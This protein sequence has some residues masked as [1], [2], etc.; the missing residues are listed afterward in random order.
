[1]IPFSPENSKKTLLWTTIL[2]ALGLGILT[3]VCY[4]FD[5]QALRSQEN[6]FNNQQALQT[7][8]A[9]ESLKSELAT[10]TRNFPFLVREP[11]RRLAHNELTI[12][13]FR[14]KFKELGRAFP[15]IIFGAMYLAP[16]NGNILFSQKRAQT[17]SL[18]QT[19]SQQ[20]QKIWPKFQASPSLAHEISFFIAQHKQFVRIFLPFRAKNVLQGIMV[21]YVD[22]QPFVD[23]Y[24][25][26]MHSGKFGA[27]Y[28]LSE[29][30]TIIFDHEHNIIGRNV[31][32]SLH[33]GYPEL[34][35]IDR[36][37]LTKHEGTGSYSFT[38]KR[39]GTTQRKLVAWDT[40]PLD[41]SGHKIIVAMSAPDQG[42]HQYIRTLWP[43]RYIIVIVMVLLALAGIIIFINALTT[44]RLILSKEQSF[45]VIDLLPDATFVIDTQNRIMAWNKAIE[46]M[47]GIP[48]ERVLG[49]NNFTEIIFGHP[50]PLLANYLDRDDLEIALAYPSFQKENGCLSAEKFIPELYDGKGAHLWFTASR[51]YDTRDN[52]I[53]AIESIRDISQFKKTEKALQDSR[54]RFTL[55]VEGNYT[56]IWDWDKL[57]DTVY[58]APRWKK[59]IGFDDDEFPNDIEAWKERIHPEDYE[60]VVETN[61]NLSPT[62]PC[63]EIEYRIRSKNGEY[64]WIAGHG[65]GI[66]DDQGVLYRMAGSH[67]D[68]TERKQNELILEALLRISTTSNRVRKTEYLFKEIHVILKELIGAENFFIAMWNKDRSTITFPYFVDEFDD[69]RCYDNI[70]IDSTLEQPGLISWVLRNEKPLF[71]THDHP[72][73]HECRGSKPA[74]W[75]GVPIIIGSSTRGVLCVQDYHDANRFTEK[76]LDFLFAVAEQTALALDR[77]QN[78]QKMA[79]YAMHDPLTNLPN[80]ALFIDRLELSI[81]RSQR[82]TMYNF[83]VMM[84]DLDRFKKINDSMG[85]ATGDKLL[86]QLSSRILP[87]LR[88]VDTIARIGG[89]EFAVLAEDFHTPREIIVIAKRI[90]AAIQQPFTIGGK[91]IHTN[92]S[93]GIVINTLH[94]IQPDTILRDA[95]I[96]MYEAKNLGPGRVRVF[97]K[98]MHRQAVEVVKLENDLRQALKEEQINV[99][100][101]PVFS[102]DPLHIS[103]VEALARWRHPEKGII[104]PDVFIPLAEET[105]LI[106]SLGHYI[107]NTACSTLAQWNQTYAGELPLIMAV[108]LSA[109]QL[110]HP[111]IVDQVDQAMKNYG[112]SGHMLKLEIT[113][114]TFM[115][116]P[117]TSQMVL[118]MLKKLGVYLAVDDFGTGY[119][120]LAYLQKLPVDTLKVD[121]SFVMDLQTNPKSR[122]IAQAI[123][124]LAHSLGKDV[125]AEGVETE[126]QLAILKEMGCEK[127]QGFY[128]SKPMF[129][130]ETEKFLQN[131]Y[132]K[133]RSK[134]ISTS[135]HGMT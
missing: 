112:I 52:V 107:L 86:V 1:M 2:S 69:G 32:D 126:E 46:K 4:I 19:S 123:L 11:V 78:E 51:L 134:N 97:N 44:R 34:E 66:W 70:E 72:I 25:A 35:D 108:N 13:L 20:L 56:G 67:R 114:S 33:A 21:L 12:P 89:D 49:C 31:F 104:G 42:I 26:P 6:L 96:A 125:I 57:T 113:E 5:T 129:K 131:Q 63:F 128:F 79:F 50:R 81:K 132:E 120:S 88:G 95:D 37:M 85:H 9:T 84:I 61:R 115:E 28:L 87:L 22:I 93:I 53:G 24:I 30:G 40:A 77:K 118:G 18:H 90:L 23:Q 100:Y 36:Q 60:M 98:N 73:M 101:Q 119:S 27:A 111:H 3:I 48:K 94:Y 71:L 38:L 7:Y 15:N 102:I 135:L 41:Q 68:I 105:G 74:V 117:H 122:V 76:D 59:I 82:H 45:T 116:H 64:K 109:K 16:D 43:Q 14:T 47:T 80:R 83:A 58:F 65:I 103:G 10:Y 29:N 91:Q 54:D 110:A 99:A 124:A 130:D 55:A 121:R 17:A 133:H 106:H 8:L 92:A 75:L 39:G 127:V 62:T